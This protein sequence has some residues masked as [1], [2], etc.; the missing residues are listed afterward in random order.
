MLVSIMFVTCLSLCNI[1]R[2]PLE[3]DLFTRAKFN[4]KTVKAQK[5]DRVKFRLVYTRN[6]RLKHISEKLNFSE[7]YYNQLIKYDW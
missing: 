6:A 4:A 7:K 5:L 2:T 1:Y 3:L